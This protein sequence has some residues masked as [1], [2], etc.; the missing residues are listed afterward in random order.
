MRIRTTLLTLGLL[1]MATTA[2]GAPLRISTG[3]AAPWLVDGNPVVAES[4]IATPYW[5]NNFG[6]GVWVGTA[7]GDGN[8]AGGAAG[9]VYTFTLNIG[10]YFG[11]PGSFNVQYSADNNVSWSITNGTLGGSTACGGCYDLV[12]N[13][14]GTFNA[15]SVLT[16]TVTNADHPSPM[17]LI[18]VGE[19]DSI[20]EP[21]TYAMF[22]TGAVAIL[23]ARIRRKK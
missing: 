6:D 7:A 14:N 9:G 4:P 13:L 22:A 2:F 11:L 12:H 18:V 20:P 10:A 21:S 3:T 15:D 8:L 1:A 23:A 16:A 19:G 17:G 5:I